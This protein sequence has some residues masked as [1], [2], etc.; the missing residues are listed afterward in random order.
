MIARIGFTGT[1]RGCTP[2]QYERL[3]FVL[4]ELR[5]STANMEHE[6]H[7]G[8]CIGADADAHTLWAEPSTTI[9]HPP[10]DD[11]KRAYCLV[12]LENKHAPKPYLRRNEDIV[13]S[14]DILVACPSGKREARR[15][16]TWATIRYARRKQ[17]KIIV[18]FPD[19]S[20][21]IEKPVV[22]TR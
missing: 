13:D 4:R 20:F 11:S 3:L 22:A 21:R 14:T 6:L 16:G 12:P 17:R 8:D 19:G 15:S 10:M 2:A 18:I 9:L 7:H 5:M 1:Q